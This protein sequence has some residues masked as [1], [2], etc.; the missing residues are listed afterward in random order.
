MPPP[1]LPRLPTSPLKARFLPRILL[2]FFSSSAKPEWNSNHKLIITHPV[3]SIMESCNSMAELKQIQAHM[4]RTGLLAHR[5]PASRVLAFCVLSDYGDLNHARLV[6]AQIPD[7]NTYIWNTMIRGYTKAQLPRSSLFLFCQMIRAHVVMDSR[8]LVFVL[9]A[10]EQFSEVFL[11][12]EIHCMI[13]KLGF[14]SDLLVQNGLTHFYVKNGLLE[15]ARKVFDELCQRDVVSW[16]TM[17]DGYSQKGLPDEAL[18]LFYRMLLMSI[19]PNEVTMI[20]VLSAISQLGHLRLGKLVHEYIRKSDLNV[21]INLMNALVDMYGKCDCVDSAREVFDSMGIKDVF[22][23]TSMVNAYAKCGDLQLA[24]KFFDSMPERNAVS[25]SSMIAAY[26]QSNHA[27]E[28]LDL[29]HEMI[30][31]RVKPID[32]TLVSVLS[33][34]AQSGCLDLGRW[35]YDH[36]INGKIIKLRMNLANAFIDMYAKCGDIKAAARLFNEMPERDIVSWNAMI[37]AYAVH[38]YGK[39]ALIL[40]E[41]LKSKGMVPDDITFVG[42]LSACSHAG[43]VVEGQRHFKDMKS[44]FGLEPKSVHYACQ[45]DLLGKVGLLEDAYE[46]ARSTP[47]EPDEA[48]WGALLNACRMHGNVE[49][50]KYAGDKLLGLDPGDSGIYVLLS[51]M[52]A[53]RNKWDDVKKVRRMMRDRGVKK[54]PGCSSIE[55]DGKFHEFF[56]ADISHVRSKDIYLT[57]DNIYL[58]LRIEGYVPKS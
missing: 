53:T 43:L 21:T 56:V 52:Y 14:D 10:C 12:E 17:I 58:Q 36:F 16:T 50:G 26:A 35:I 55:V 28:A 25:W 5:F 11:G 48:G 57:L 29:F 7:P 22:S 44:I 20:T 47:M 3:L 6:F 18:R 8:T 45:I 49:L 13:F 4:T 37:M 42:V 31:M 9:K 38:G 51:S 54:T 40:F 24:R 1:L 27:K 30:A 41:H 46:L 19:Q 32:A 34:C 33:A 2:E 15:S 39:E 23:W